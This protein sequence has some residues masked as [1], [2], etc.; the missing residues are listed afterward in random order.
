MISYIYHHMLKLALFANPEDQ[1]CNRH[2]DQYQALRKAF[3]NDIEDSPR[4]LIR[5]QVSSFDSREFDAGLAEVLSCCV[6]PDV[7]DGWRQWNIWLRFGEA[8]PVFA[9]LRTK[10]WRG[11]TFAWMNEL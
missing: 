6:Q 5:F 7:I 2:P 9:D 4:G 11:S 3:V 8:W 1:I 10:S